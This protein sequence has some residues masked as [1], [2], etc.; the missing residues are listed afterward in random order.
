MIVMDKP[1]HDENFSPTF[2]TNKQRFKLVVTFST[3]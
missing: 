2:L 1:N 3:A